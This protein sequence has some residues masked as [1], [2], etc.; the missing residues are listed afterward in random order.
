MHFVCDEYD[1]CNSISGLNERKTNIYYHSKL[2]SNNYK[3]NYIYIRMILVPNYI[4]YD[5]SSNTNRVQVS[6]VILSDQY[7][8]CDI[9]M[10]KKFNLQ[11][12]ETYIFK[13]CQNNHTNVLEWLKMMNLLQRYDHNTLDYASLEG[14]IN[15]LNWWKNSGLE[16]KYSEKALDGA[17]Q[18]EHITVLD[19]WKNSGLPLKY[20]KKAMD[21]ASLLGSVGALDWWK[22]S[23]LPLKYSEKALSNACSNS[24]LD[25]LYWWCN[26]GLF[27]G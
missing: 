4:C 14:H 3:F 5:K 11:I 15:V 16:L 17:S 21:D 6:K 19:W 24:H 8:L 13:L 1:C 25:V 2:L 27:Q 18:F 7:Y 20:S 22:N 10:I 9:K 23:G 12:A 26:S